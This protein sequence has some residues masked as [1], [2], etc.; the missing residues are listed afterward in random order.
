MTRTGTTVAAA[1]VLA[2]LAAPASAG[3][4]EFTGQ[5]ESST[6][7]A[8]YEERHRIEGSCKA[9]VFQPLEHRVVYIRRAESNRHPFAEKRLDYRSSLLRPVVKYQQPDFKESLEIT[10]PAS[11][12]AAIVWQQPGGE[13]KQSNLGGSNDLVVDAG[14]DNLVRQNWHK[15]TTGESVKFRFLA[16][17]RGTDYAFILEPAQN[18]SIEVDHLVQIRPE[19]L[20]LKF[21]VDPIVLGY[22]NKGALTAY[23]GLTNV[24]ENADQNHTATIHYEVNNY[25]ECDLIP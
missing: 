8:L 1:I 18:L 7:E 9:G 3:L 12:S 16:P 23:S 21:L 24:R 25:P 2:A 5:A 15:L 22:N 6:G 13:I 14:F 10:Y 20:V 19:S 17:T 4:F 11:D